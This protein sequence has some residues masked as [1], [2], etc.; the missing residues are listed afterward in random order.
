MK[1]TDDDP[2]KSPQN[3]KR[4]SLYTGIRPGQVS[5]SYSCMDVSYM[6]FVLDVA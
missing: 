6:L 2:K 5:L 3:N 4:A 1:V